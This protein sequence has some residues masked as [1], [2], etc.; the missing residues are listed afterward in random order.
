MH[1]PPRCASVL[2]CQTQVIS[3]PA[4]SQAVLNHFE[5]LTLGP[6]APGQPGDVG[7]V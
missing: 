5:S 3:W 4:C 1:V 6:A 7:K 2:Y